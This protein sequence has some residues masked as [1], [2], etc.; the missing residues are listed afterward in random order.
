M[1]PI[2][3]DSNNKLFRQVL[4]NEPTEKTEPTENASS[5]RSVVSCSIRRS[6]ALHRE[7]HMSTA[8]LPTNLLERLAEVHALC[9]QMRF[10]QLLATVGLLG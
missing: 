8:L 7:T 6:V 10:G 4:E 9:P 5:V 3:S 1:Q 2:A